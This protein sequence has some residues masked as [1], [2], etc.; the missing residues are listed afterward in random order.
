[1]EKGG[2]GEGLEVVEVVGGEVGGRGARTGMD[3]FYC[4]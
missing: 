1:M 4:D 2:L 3:F